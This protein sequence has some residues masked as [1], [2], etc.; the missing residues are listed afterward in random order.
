MRKIGLGFKLAIC[1]YI[2]KLDDSLHFSHF[3][4]SWNFKVGRCSKA[5]L[6]LEILLFHIFYLGW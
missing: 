5:L 3:K 2:K 6:F 1:L 4:V